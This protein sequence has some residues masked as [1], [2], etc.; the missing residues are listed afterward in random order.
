MEVN[1]IIL[2]YNS[3]VISHSEK[4]NEEHKKETSL[5]WYECYDL[6]SRWIAY[7]VSDPNY[8]NKISKHLNTERSIL[9]PVCRYTPNFFIPYVLKFKINFILKPANKVDL[10]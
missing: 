2:M 8:L 3:D 7:D 6:K 10:K 5:K 9:L 4:K 1:D